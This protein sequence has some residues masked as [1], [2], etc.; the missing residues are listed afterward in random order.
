[1]GEVGNF[2]DYHFNKYLRNYLDWLENETYVEI[3][4]LG[5]GAKNGERILKKSLLKEIEY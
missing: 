5:T 4:A 3:S 2:E 1:M